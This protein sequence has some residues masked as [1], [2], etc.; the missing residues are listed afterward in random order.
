MTISAER[1]KAPSNVNRLAS[2][3][4]EPTLSTSRCPL[5]PVSLSGPWQT[6]W[7]GL[8]SAAHMFVCSLSHLVAWHAAQCASSPSVYPAWR[9]EIKQKYCHEDYSQRRGSHHWWNLSA[10][11]LGEEKGGDCWMSYK[12]VVFCYVTDMGVPVN[13]LKALTDWLA[14]KLSSF[15]FQLYLPAGCDAVESWCRQLP[16]NSLAW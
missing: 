14:A 8:L 4:P 7:S 12:K 16:G 10:F 15:L 9:I 5:L 1:G 2:P 3:Q 11:P 13:C 6:L